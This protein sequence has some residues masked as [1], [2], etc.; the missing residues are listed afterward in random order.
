MTKHEL[1]LLSD[2]KAGQKVRFMEAHAGYGMTGRL[3]AMG[4]LPGSVFE[5]KSNNRPGP[6]IV[7]VKGS[8]MVLGRGMAEKILVK[9]V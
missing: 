1:K 6:I 4:L 3:A 8:K 7:F 5:V 2:V 9:T